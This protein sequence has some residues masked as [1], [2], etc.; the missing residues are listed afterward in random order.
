M[1]GE[2]VCDKHPPTLAQLVE[3]STVEVKSVNRIVACSIQ[4]SW[5]PLSWC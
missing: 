2:K 3:H 1:N 5:S 4:A